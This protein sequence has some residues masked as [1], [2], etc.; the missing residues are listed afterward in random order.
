LTTGLPDMSLQ[1]TKTGKIYQITNTLP[2]GHK[3]VPNGGI[4]FQMAKDYNQPF[5][6]QG[7]PK[8]TQIRIFGLKIYHLATLLDKS[9]QNP[10]RKRAMDLVSLH[11]LTLLS[12]LTFNVM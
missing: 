2:N 6:F 9:I 12:K 5:P 4:I 11:I 8:F 1:Y 10:F 7:P 3:N